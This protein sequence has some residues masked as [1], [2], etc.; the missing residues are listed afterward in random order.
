M[1]AFGDKRLSDEEER[2][3]HE[4]LLSLFWD[5]RNAP[6]KKSKVN[7]LLKEAKEASKIPADQGKV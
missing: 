3:V 2:L 6:E 7:K 1:I 5:T 4:A